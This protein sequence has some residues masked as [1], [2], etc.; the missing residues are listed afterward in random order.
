MT[1]ASTRPP[2]GPFNIVIVSIARDSIHTSARQAD[3]AGMRAP[4]EKN[5]AKADV[6]G[7][8]AGA[9][10]GAALAGV[11]G[12][13]IGAVVEGAAMSLAEAFG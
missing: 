13:A 8:L 3:G 1:N 10:A 12:A 4:Q 2:S 7:A 9:G 6:Q 11:I 5:V